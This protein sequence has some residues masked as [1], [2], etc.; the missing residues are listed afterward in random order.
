MKGL[1]ITISNKTVLGEK[2]DEI[3]VRVPPFEGRAHLAIELAKIVKAKEREGY[4]KVLIK[5]DGSIMDSMMF[6]MQLQHEFNEAG[7]TLPI[8]GEN[9]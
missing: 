1:R 5:V 6:Q 4:G 8:Y 2:D 3:R 7:V 9:R